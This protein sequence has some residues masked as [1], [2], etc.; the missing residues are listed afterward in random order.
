MGTTVAVPVT[1][2][3]QAVQP[4]QTA[5]EVPVTGTV[6]QPVPAVTVD[7]ERTPAVQADT[8]QAVR[9]CPKCGTPREAGSMFCEECGSRFE[10]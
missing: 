2:P 4:S 5:T 6:A 7:Q 1:E 9:F 10:E 3:A 8:V